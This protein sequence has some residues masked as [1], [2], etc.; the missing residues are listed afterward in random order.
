M[1]GHHFEQQVVISFCP[2][3]G[4]KNENP[5]IESRKSNPENIKVDFR[6]YSE[7]VLYKIF[8]FRKIIS[9]YVAKIY[10]EIFS[11]LYITFA[12][13]S[14]KLFSIL[15][16]RKVPQDHGILKKRLKTSESA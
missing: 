12:V 8:E 2:R 16:V 13:K 9:T 1:L 6:R 7:E 14:T 3:K 10:V 11:L 5:E 4:L 15:P